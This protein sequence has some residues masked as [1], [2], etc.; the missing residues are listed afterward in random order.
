MLT[1]PSSTYN[2]RW[3]SV[4]DAPN[5]PQPVQP[6]GVPILIGG[7]GPRTTLKLVAKYADIC[8]FAGRPSTVRRLLGTL[9]EHCERQGRDPATVCRTLLTTVVIRDSLRAAEAVIDRHLDLSNHP[10]ER[11]QTIREMFVVGDE[12]MVSEQLAELIS[13]GL[14]G[15]IITVPDVHRPEVLD[16]TGRV[17]RAV[18]GTRPL[19]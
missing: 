16:V 6:G 13:T 1:S 14:D 11:V 12:A 2:G 4:V 9:D 17:L 10:P 5:Y 7:G 19:P 8:N 18:T 3:Y 15:L